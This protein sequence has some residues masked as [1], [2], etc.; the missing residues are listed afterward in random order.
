MVAKKQ[1]SSPL[2]PVW[3][4]DL[5][6]WLLGPGRPVL[7]A[8]ALVGVFGGGAYLAWRRIGPRILRSPEYRVGP[9]QVEIT[10]LP[11]WIHRN[12][13][14]FQA[15]V[16]R[17]PALDGPLSIMDDDLTERIAKTFKLHPWVAKVGRVTK[18]YP[19]PAS[20]KVELV[21]R[22]PVCMVDVPGWAYAVD[23]DG[24]VLPGEDF[25]SME[26]TRYPHLTGVDRKPAVQAGGR[27]VDLKV[28]GGAKIA[29]AFGPAWEKMQLQYIDA[30]AADPAAGAAG[31]AGGDSPRRAME[32][33]F[34]LRTRQGSRI[35]WGYAPGAPIAGE[36]PAAE[37]VAR[38][39]QYFAE[40][41]TLDGP[42]GQRQDLDVRVL[43]KGATSR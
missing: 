18:Q 25:T 13:G 7:V 23:A 2:V 36:I 21:Y 30:L 20:V 9:A 16:F 5:V 8:A 17:S 43:G 37:K 19:N 26:A 31:I 39:Q 12:S 14:E 4:R 3:L 38:L 32:P 15:E 24:V 40:N 10:P 29:E 42:Q 33:F 41:D 35:L 34:A 1:N 6:S 11:G 27:W 22:E 28:V